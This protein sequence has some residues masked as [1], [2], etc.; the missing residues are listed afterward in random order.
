MGLSKDG[1]YYDKASYLGFDGDSKIYAVVE[2]PDGDGWMIDWRKAYG[3]IPHP[4]KRFGVFE[5]VEEAAEALD[6]LAVK[7]EWH[8][9]QRDED[10]KTR[11]V[12]TSFC[13]ASF[14]KEPVNA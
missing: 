1:K 13:I 3:V 8:Y 4:V 5:T 10:P 11:K 9:M 6:K 14:D 12:Q 7:N 2:S